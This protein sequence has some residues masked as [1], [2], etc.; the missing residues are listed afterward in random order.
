M[1]RGDGESI[2]IRAVPPQIVVGNER[3]LET[4]PVGTAQ[5]AVQ[6]HLVGSGR[7]N[8]ITRMGE[9]L[10]HQVIGLA[11]FPVIDADAALLT[12]DVNLACLVIVK[13]SSRETNV[14]GISQLDPSLIQILIMNGEVVVADITAGNRNRSFDHLEEYAIE[15]VLHGDD[16]AGLYVGH[17]GVPV[18]AVRLVIGRGQA[19]DGVVM[20]RIKV[21]TTRVPVVVSPLASAPIV[22]GSCD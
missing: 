14:L 4:V 22:V 15:Q 9:V 19:G 21:G 13:S 17:V 6:E 12:L 20:R 16:A 3:V 8:C 11:S 18:N 5:I 1:W 2:A 10:R 7:S